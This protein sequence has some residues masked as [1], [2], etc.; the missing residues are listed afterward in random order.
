M[1]GKS[2]VLDV[3]A[4]DTIEAIKQ[5][6]AVIA[7]MDSADCVQLTIEGL[8]LFPDDLATLS[9]YDI[10]SECI[11]HATY[12]LRGGAGPVINGSLKAGSYYCLL[13]SLTLFIFK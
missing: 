3:K 7:D 8:E 4:S 10:T 1:T 6:V 11:C 2:Y 12:N 13:S 9:Y 5:Q